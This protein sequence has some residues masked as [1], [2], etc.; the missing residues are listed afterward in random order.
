[1]TSEV[2]KPDFTALLLSRAL[3]TPRINYGQYPDDG[4]RPKQAIRWIKVGHS[5]K[6]RPKP[7]KCLVALR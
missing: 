4:C 1:M 7:N 6:Q 2:T 5:C 3:R